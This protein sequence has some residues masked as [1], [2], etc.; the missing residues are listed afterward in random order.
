M[1]PIENGPFFAVKVFPG[2]FATFAGLKTN[3]AAQALDRDGAAISGLYA[4]GAD[5][6]SIMGGCY[7]AGCINLGPAMTFGY[8]ARDTPPKP[9]PMRQTYPMQSLADQLPTPV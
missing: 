5:M 7:P 4:V 2:S 3:E 1:A 8:I 6:E 9:M